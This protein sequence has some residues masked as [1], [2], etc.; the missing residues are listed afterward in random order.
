MLELRPQLVVTIAPAV[1]VTL[2]GHVT[3]SPVVGLTVSVIVMV[4]AKQLAQVV[5]GGA[6]Q[7]PKLTLAE[8]LPPLVKETVGVDVVTLKPDTSMVTVGAL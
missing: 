7:L 4:P 8:P 2:A 3:A 5:C 6:P 1:N